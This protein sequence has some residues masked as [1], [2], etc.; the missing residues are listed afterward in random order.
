MARL[1]AVS[2]HSLCQSKMSCPQCGHGSLGGI[3]SGPLV[4]V[5]IIL[6]NSQSRSASRIHVRTPRDVAGL[7]VASSFPNARLGTHLRHTLIR[8]LCGGPDAKQSFAK[9]PAGTEFGHEVNCGKAGCGLCRRERSVTAAA[10]SGVSRR[11]VRR[12]MRRPLAAGQCRG[13]QHRSGGL[14]PPLAGIAARVGGDWRR[15]ETRAEHG[16]SAP[17]SL[18]RAQTRRRAYNRP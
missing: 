9:G 6:E 17:H 15:Q 1:C 8:D 2:Y 11:G 12:D 16:V 7:A 13:F 18:I 3:A 10:G 14:R 5:L 4:L